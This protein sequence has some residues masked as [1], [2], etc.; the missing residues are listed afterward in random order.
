MDWSDFPL[1]V[2][3]ILVGVVLV[4]VVGGLVIGLLARRSVRRD[5]K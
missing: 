4:A 2:L 1:M 5:E 3:L